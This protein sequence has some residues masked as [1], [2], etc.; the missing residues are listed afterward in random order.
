MRGDQ[1]EYMLRL[2]KAILPGS[3]RPGELCQF[4]HWIW[5]GGESR[6]RSRQLPSTSRREKAESFANRHPCTQWIGP[7]FQVADLG[8]IVE[9]AQ[10]IDKAFGPA[11]P[12]L[13]A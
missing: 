9:L 11:S 7:D 2:S 10:D 1:E 3:F 8:F 12:C 5:I 6:S 4:A 13:D